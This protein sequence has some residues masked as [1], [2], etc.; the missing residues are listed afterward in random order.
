MPIRPF[1]VLV[2]VSIAAIAATASPVVAATITV[3]SQNFVSNNVELDKFDGSGLLDTGAYLH[4]DFGK[5]GASYFSALAFDA[6]GSRRIA[7]K[8]IVSNN[9]EIDAFDNTGLLT[10]GFYLHTTFGNLGA[11]YFSDFAFDASGTLRVASKNTVSNNVEIDAFDNTGLLTNGFYLHTSIGN[12]GASYFDALAFDPAGHLW[13]ASKNTVSN[14]IEIDEFDDEGLLIDGFYLH[15]AFGNL[16]ASYFTDFA[17]DPSGN[18]W[19]ASKNVVSNNIE[20]D[21]FDRSGLYTDGYYL[22]TDSGYL[23][24]AYFADFAFNPTATQANPPGTVPEPETWMMLMTGLGLLG[25]ASRH[26][27]AKR[28]DRLE[29]V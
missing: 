15:T 26:R 2:M 17:F 12:L 22:H 10:D 13:V 21:Q 14:N 6:S 3:A 24:A 1:P 11:S 23:G 7:S 20:I 8:N 25:T 18:L 5:L 29:T 28:R 9:V 4:T 27:Q 16:G 19:A